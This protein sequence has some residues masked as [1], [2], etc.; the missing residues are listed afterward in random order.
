MSLYCIKSWTKID[1]HDSSISSS[2]FKMFIKCESKNCVSWKKNFFFILFF[3]KGFHKRLTR[4]RT[5]NIVFGLLTTNL[6]AFVRCKWQLK[7][8]LLRQ[9]RCQGC[10]ILKTKCL[11]SLAYHTRSSGIIWSQK[12]PH[13][14]TKTIWLRVKT[15]WGNVFPTTWRVKACMLLGAVLS[16]ADLHTTLPCQPSEWV[17]P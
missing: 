7:E 15:G 5:L 12:C 1:K 14:Y 11:L 6:T 3:C 17:G 10:C 13:I 16:C 9:L 4:W 8:Y 2:V